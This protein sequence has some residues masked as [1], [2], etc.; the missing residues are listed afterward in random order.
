[1]IEHQFIDNN[2]TRELYLDAMFCN[3]IQSDLSD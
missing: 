1:M 3:F 2:E